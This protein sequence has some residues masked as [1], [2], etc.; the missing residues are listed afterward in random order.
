MVKIAEMSENRM[1]NNK[2]IHE[3]KLCAFSQPLVDMIEVV[4][5]Q[6]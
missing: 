5:K 1:H 4:V 2:H 3:H 6:N